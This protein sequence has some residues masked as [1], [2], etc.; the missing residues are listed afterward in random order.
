M[1]MMNSTIPATLALRSLLMVGLLVPSTLLIAERA[2]QAQRGVDARVRVPP[3]VGAAGGV[4]AAAVDEPAG[5]QVAADILRASPTVIQDGYGSAAAMNEA[6]TVLVIGAS[7]TTVADAAAV[8]SV[9]IYRYDEALGWM[10]VQKLNCPPTIIAGAATPA[11]LSLFGWSVA[12]SGNTIVVGAP[13]VSTGAVAIAGKAYVFQLNQVD[14][15]WGDITLEARV[16]N[17]ILGPSDP[18]MIGFFGGAVAIDVVAEGDTR[19]AVGSPFRGAANQGGV[20][21]FEG[22]GNTFPQKQFLIPSAV[23]G[24]DNFGTKLALEGN[25]LVVGSQVAD[26]EDRLNCGSAHVY[27]RAAKS[28]TWSTTPE[29]VL[30]AANGERDDGFGS[31]VAVQGDTIAIGAPGVDRDAKGVTTL[32]NGSVYM[33]RFA[34]GNWVSDG[35]ELFA[36]EPNGGNVF[37]FSLAL[38]NAGTK[39]LVGCPGYETTLVNAGAGFDFVRLAGVWTLQP[40][41]LWSTSAITSQS[42]GEQTT[43]SSNGV[44]AALGSRNPAGLI[45]TRMY[46]WDY[47]SEV[48]PDVLPLGTP[49]TAQAPGADGFAPGTI[50]TTT[51]PGGVTPP[52]GLGSGGL[53]NMPVIPAT[54]VTR[55]WGLV[56]A[57]VLS[58]DRSAAR[59][60]IIMTDGL[61]DSGLAS[62]EFLGSYDPSFEVLGVGDVNGDGSG[63]VLFRDPATRKVKAWIRLGN[64]ITE[65]VTVGTTAVGDRFIGI[66][67]WSV[68][69]FDAP[70]FLH[71]NGTDAVFWVVASGALTDRIDWTMPAGEWTFFTSDVTGDGSP[72]LI[73]RDTAAG[74]L[75]RVDPE[76][77]IDAGAV[78]VAMADHGSDHRLVAAQDFDG[79]GTNDLLWEDAESEKEFWFMRS[80][81]TVRYELPWPCSLQGWA[82]NMAADFDNNG[83]ADL[84]FSKGG[85]E[86][87]VMRLE[88]EAL[89]GQRGNMRGRFSRVLERLPGG[90]TVLGVAEEPLSNLGR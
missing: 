72:D 5:W 41:D 44:R 40:S 77:N 62:Y 65:T 26:I 57:S 45:A 66:G 47:S 79:D 53:G 43:V 18:E 81:G 89:S 23:V 19:I 4:G 21:I 54:P 16:A 35:E 83:T 39:V 31:A 73:A 59:I 36:R 9:H 86:V 75:V 63:D 67:D 14:N 84:M 38:A 74:T 11:G 69:G 58:I 87:L 34:A 76:P 61:H 30:F 7:D 10:H 3:A 52:T 51:P 33:Y 20:Y 25:V 70:A 82:I 50:T 78:I 27:R 12:V 1:T 32:N 42:I 88:W 90:Y 48:L 49:P 8:G 64:R 28:G 29:A 85:T 13:A 56:R 24:Q 46:A 55:P 37:G 15:L 80:D 2:A 22:S 68:T 17:R 60:G 6:G 71:A